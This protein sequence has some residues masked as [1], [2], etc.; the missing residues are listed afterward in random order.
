MHLRLMTRL[1]G[2]NHHA[3]RALTDAEVAYLRRLAS[4]TARR[5]HGLFTTALGSIALHA[6]IA[7]IALTTAVG[8][9]TLQAQRATPIVIAADFLDPGLRDESR[10]DIGA[11]SAARAPGRVA[12]PSNSVSDTLAAKVKAL[13]QGARGNAALEAVERRYRGGSGGDGL[14]APSRGVATFAGLTAQNAQ[15]IVYVVDA[16]GSMIA[17][18]PIVIAE[19]D[20]SISQLEPGQEFSVLCFQKNGTVALPPQGRLRASS[21]ASRDACVSW[22]QG[23]VKPQG[24]SS[25]LDALQKALALKPDVIFL[26]STNITGSGQFELDRDAIL[27]ALERMNPRNADG[28]RRAVIQCVQFL[29][30][31]PAATLE[32]ISRAHGTPNGFRT[33]TRRD[34]GLE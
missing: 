6:V 25:P 18:L 22:L 29:E 14:A 19:L 8:V 13:S 28:T 24:R 20:R 2:L 26:L 16:S 5:S 7:V 27:D 9:S 4:P 3:N 10:V 33:L 17:T 30:A 11:P 23:S 15:K 31:D 1:D 21:P 34:L 12:S 32:A